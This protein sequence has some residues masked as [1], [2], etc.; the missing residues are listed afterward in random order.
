MNL[1]VLCLLVLEN[2]I[3]RKKIL[4]TNLYL[5][6]WQCFVC[7]EFHMNFDYRCIFWF[8]PYLWTMVNKQKVRPMVAI[9]VNKTDRTNIIKLP[10]L[11][12][13]YF[14]KL[15]TTPVRK[16]IV[17]TTSCFYLDFIF[18]SWTQLDL[19]HLVILV[20]AKLKYSWLNIILLLSYKVP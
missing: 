16:N 12:F 1:Q 14:R 7:I 13:P 19:D 10:T 3:W 4:T 5:Q 20:Q 17:L 6:R 2:P 8:S 11:H 15:I 9:V 18:C